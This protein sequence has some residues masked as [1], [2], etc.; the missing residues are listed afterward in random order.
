MTVQPLWSRGAQFVKLEAVGEEL[1]RGGDVAKGCEGDLGLTG[2]ICES[3]GRLGVDKVGVVA[4]IGVGV[5]SGIG[6]CVGAGPGARAWCG[7]VAVG[8]GA[9]NGFVVG[10]GAG[11]GEGG[12]GV[13]VEGDGTGCWF[14]GEGVDGVEKGGA[15]AGVAEVV[16]AL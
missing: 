1:G 11:D 16:V 13:R 3:G 2:G 9:V 10:V 14:K 8:V 15:D 7:S 12:Q 4:G 5:G 6:V